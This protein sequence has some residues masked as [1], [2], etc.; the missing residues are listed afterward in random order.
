MI[1]SRCGACAKKDGVP[2]S[3]ERR[4]PP[5]QLSR[6]LIRPFAGGDPRESMKDYFDDELLPVDEPVPEPAAVPASPVPASPVPAPLASA[7]LV[8]E[9][10]E[11]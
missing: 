9:P 4:P 10:V 7:E 11:P 8:D 2:D 5:S 3:R 1:T 6:D